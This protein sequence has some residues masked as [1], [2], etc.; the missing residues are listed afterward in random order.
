MRTVKTTPGATAVQVVWSSRRGSRAIEHLGPAHDEAELEALKTAAQ[1]RM[2]A[3]QLELGFGLGDPGRVRA[4]ADHL[5]A[6]EPPGGRP[7]ARLPGAGARGRGGGDEV[8]RHLVPA[9][10]IEP[11]SKLDSMRV[12]EEAGGDG[13]VLPHPEARLPAYAEEG[14]GSGCRPP[15]PRTPGS[16]GQPGAL[17]RVHALLQDRRGRRVLRARV[18]QESAGWSRRSPSAC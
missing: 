11:T 5:L 6:D 2:A 7:G 9:R 8:F 18:L 1:Q 13:G 16:A 17:R 3:D 14:S 10:I 12:L 15:A 4:A